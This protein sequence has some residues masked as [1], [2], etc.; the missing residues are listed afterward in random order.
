MPPFI[1]FNGL[2]K[3]EILEKEKAYKALGYN[4]EQM[5]EIETEIHVLLYT[6]IRERDMK[7][8]INQI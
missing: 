3:K 2:N 4:K 8:Q 5:K 6:E 1:L 7:Q